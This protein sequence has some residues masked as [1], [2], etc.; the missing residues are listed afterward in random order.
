MP[1]ASLEYHINY[2]TRKKILFREKDGRYERYYVKQLDAKDREVLSA[3]RQKR[4]RE[5]VLV[6][7]LNK[8]VK[9]QALLDIL[10]IPPSTLSLYLKYLVGHQILERNKI[11]HENIYTVQDENRLAK[12]LVSYRSSLV[13][14]LIDKALTTW[15]ETRFRKGKEN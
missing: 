4:L 13:D 7:L 12:V 3:L 5:T 6:V 2:M 8:K 14:R 10:Q 1:L 9:Y 15:M 11:G